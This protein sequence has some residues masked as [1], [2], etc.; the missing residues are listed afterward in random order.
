[1][2]TLAPGAMIFSLFINSAY[3]E[4]ILNKLM[5]LPVATT[6]EELY[7]T[8]HNQTNRLSSCAKILNTLRQVLFQ[9]EMLKFNSFTP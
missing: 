9:G 2:T 4:T 7:T 6:T 8:P 5:V 3:R 1:M